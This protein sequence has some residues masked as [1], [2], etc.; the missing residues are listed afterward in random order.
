MLFALGVMAFWMH[1]SPDSFDQRQS[2]V[3]ASARSDLRPLAGAK[4][5]PSGGGMVE[6]DA[7][8]AAKPAADAAGAAMRARAEPAGT[9]QPRQQAAGA[10]SNASNATAARVR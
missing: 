6:G 1:R 8:S 10:A 9:A 2:M 5:T 3:A 7:A 4:I